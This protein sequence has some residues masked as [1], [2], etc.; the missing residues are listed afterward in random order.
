MSKI[1]VT[2]VGA[3]NGRMDGRMYERKD[4]WTFGRAKSLPSLHNAKA[5]LL[6]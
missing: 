3:L 2:R 1:F 6:Q 5:N 4:V